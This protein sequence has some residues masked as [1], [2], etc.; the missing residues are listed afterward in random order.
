M[1]EKNDSFKQRR[2]TDMFSV[3]DKPPQDDEEAQEARDIEDFGQEK[4]HF[5]KW[6]VVNRVTK[7]KR[8]ALDRDEEF[9]DEDL[10]KTWRDVLG[11]PPPYG[12]SK[13]ELDT[14][15]AFQKRKW[16]FQ[17]IQRSQGGNPRSQKKAKTSISVLRSA[18]PG[19]L[20]GF[21]QRAQRTLLTAPWQVIQIVATAT[22]GEYKLWAL[23]QSELHQVKLTVPRVFYANLKEPKVAEEGALF[24]KCNRTLPRARQVY[25][26]YMY[27]VPEEI[28]Q[29]HGK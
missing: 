18:A 22:P 6:P 26:L 5:D 24:K 7:R 13:E 21:I 2:I 16:N 15:L 9:N 23:V 19:S 8:G 17:A 10:T 28:F 11:N 20:G 14:W 25:H 3:I 4:S 29:E 1:L 12:S 27:S